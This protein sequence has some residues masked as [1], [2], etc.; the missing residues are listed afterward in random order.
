M[1]LLFDPLF[2]LP[3]FAGLVAATVAAVI[4]LYLRLRAEWLAAL[5]FAHVAG[6]GGVAGLL[7]GATP[8]LAAL[9][10]SALAV[11]VKGALQRTG[12]D[13]YAW[14]ILFGWATMMVGASFS[15]HAKMLGDTLLEGQLY[16]AGPPE[17]WATL[18]VACATALLLPLLSRRLLRQRLFPG[19][20][21]ANGL[22]AWPVTVGFDLLAA[23]TIAVSALVMGVMAAFALVFMPAWVAFGVAGGW[24]RAVAWTAGL[25]GGVY[26]GAY[27]AAMA[28]DLP[29]A[30]V[31]VGLAA[32]L[33]PLRLLRRFQAGAA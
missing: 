30:P 23:A 17:L 13:V 27:V 21:A 5:G 26:T 11:A 4:G 33:A 18:A 1:D 3:F 12:N 28:A 20:D 32:L 19:H 15:H 9:G 25:A 10:A 31:L 22:R 14:L 24:R 6:A 8:L 7:L 16:F 2:R 29:F